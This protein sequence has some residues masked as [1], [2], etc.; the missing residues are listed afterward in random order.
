[1]LYTPLGSARR[2]LPLVVMLHGCSQSAADFATGTLNQGSVPSFMNVVATI[3]AANKV[4]P[5]LYSTAK[6]ITAVL[7]P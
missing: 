4:D 3:L 5:A 1:M 6:P 7:K 2:R